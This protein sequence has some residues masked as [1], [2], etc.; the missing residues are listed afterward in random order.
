MLP[1]SVQ[2]KLTRNNSKCSWWSWGR[3]LAIVLLIAVL[4]MPQLSVYADGG[5]T[6]AGSGSSAQSELSTDT[7]DNGS[8]TSTEQDKTSLVEIPTTDETELEVTP[9][10][11]DVSSS[12]ETPGQE[13]ALVSEF[14][15]DTEVN[16]PGVSTADKKT[17]VSVEDPEQEEG[18]SSET[19][20]NPES[21]S[22]D[23]ASANTGEGTTEVVPGN[24]CDQATNAVSGDEGVDAADNCDGTTK[25]K[26]NAQPADSDDD[27]AQLVEQPSSADANEDDLQVVDESSATESLLPINET[28]VPD[29][30]FFVDGVK[31]SFLPSDGDCQGQTNC[32]ASSTPI[33][34]A[35]NAV[36]SGLTPDNS[37]IY[38]EGGDFSEDIHIENLI[39]LTLQGSTN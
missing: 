31:H 5:D 9:S 11:E 33:Q 30:Y 7:V 23:T 25:A 35:I 38:I 20:T 34:D 27:A 22:D 36:A 4:S 10:P 16:E 12:V 18:S 37:T 29:P 2:D 19:L 8:T 26:S 6:N 21:S 32:A 14:L 17:T 15:A 13:E 39:S 24:E 28:I 1:I 3:W